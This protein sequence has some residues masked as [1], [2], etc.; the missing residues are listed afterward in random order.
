MRFLLKPRCVVIPIVAT[1]IGWE[2]GAS[3]SCA[4]APAWDHTVIA[5][6]RFRPITTAAVDHCLAY[7]PVPLGPV[8]DGPGSPP[9]FQN[10]GDPPWYDSILT[11]FDFSTPAA[12]SS[13]VSIQIFRQNWASL[14]A[15]ASTPTNFKATQAG[16]Y[17]IPVSFRDSANVNL[18]ARTSS[19]WDYNYVDIFAPHGTNYLGSACERVIGVGFGYPQTGNPT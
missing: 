2:S 5:G 17:D 11:Y 15:Y 19:A 1:L 18:F 13:N 8:S 7:G 12:M 14:T 4:C 6:A 9:G 16:A 3:A 10:Q